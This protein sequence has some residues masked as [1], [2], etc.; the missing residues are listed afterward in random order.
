[1]VERGRGTEKEKRER[2]KAG[3]DGNQRGVVERMA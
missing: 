1:M 3:E 2:K